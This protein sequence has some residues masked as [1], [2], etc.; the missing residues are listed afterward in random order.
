MLI[1][2]TPRQSLN[3]LINLPQ[4]KSYTYP[5][6]NPND[7]NPPLNESENLEGG[8]VEMKLVQMRHVGSLKAYV[9]EFNTKMNGTTKI[10]ELAKKLI[11]LNGVAKVDRRCIV[12]V[13]KAS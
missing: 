9:C 1:R 12:Q 7:Y 10:D 2:S 11:V 13:P 3:N 6:I 8:D 5:Q 4:N